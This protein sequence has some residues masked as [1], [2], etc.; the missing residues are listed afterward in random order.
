MEFLSKVGI[1][2]PKEAT[3]QLKLVKYFIRL[4]KGDQAQ[5]HLDVL[6]DRAPKH[7]ASRRAVALFD[8]YLKRAD[9]V[10]TQASN[11]T[12]TST[13]LEEWKSNYANPDLEADKK[14][15]ERAY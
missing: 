15:M 12:F 4:N 6:L 14:D 9:K 7:L 13:I 1:S 10:I 2:N 8:T 11:D 3:L 5:Q